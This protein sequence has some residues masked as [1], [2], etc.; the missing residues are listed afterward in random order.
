ME[1]VMSEFHYSYIKN[2]KPLYTDTD[3]LMYEIKTEDIY[4]DFTDKEEMFVFSNYLTKS[5]YYD[6][7][8][9][10]VIGKMKDETAVAP[11]EEFFRL[12]PKMYSYLV[13]D[14][15]EHKN[16]KRCE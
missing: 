10:L 14:S 8:S 5:K 12:K 2:L 13:D 4:A 1:N 15:S 3:S 6:N 7:S 16:K 11:A 9:K